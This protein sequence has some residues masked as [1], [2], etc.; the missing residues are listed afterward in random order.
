MGHAA[1]AVYG[2]PDILGGSWLDVVRMRRRC[3]VSRVSEIS[4]MAAVKAPRSRSPV[5]VMRFPQM[6]VNMC[7]WGMSARVSGGCSPPDGCCREE[8]GDS[9]RLVT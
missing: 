5:A 6:A 3:V 2:G 7:Q 8:I 1:S 4:P 9:D